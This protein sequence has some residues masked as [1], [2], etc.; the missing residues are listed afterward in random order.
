MPPEKKGSA[1]HSAE[2]AW[3]TSP[4]ATCLREGDGPMAKGFNPSVR[5]LGLSS[6]P[7]AHDLGFYSDPKLLVLKVLGWPLPGPAHSVLSLVPAKGRTTHPCP[8]GIRGTDPTGVR[9]RPLTEATGAPEKGRAGSEMKGGKVQYFS[10]KSAFAGK[11]N[12]CKEHFK[13]SSKGFSSGHN[14]ID[15]RLR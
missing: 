6:W 9:Y 2:A 14:R 7:S 3:V 12:Q 1:V 15:F 4:F 13:S 5:S 11:K 10:E 8:S